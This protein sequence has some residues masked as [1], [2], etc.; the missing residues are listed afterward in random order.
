MLLGSTNNFSNVTNKILKRRTSKAAKSRHLPIIQNFID[1]VCIDLTPWKVW[2]FLSPIYS[3]WCQ[4][5]QHSKNPV[6]QN[7]GAI[8]GPVIAVRITNATLI[9]YSNVILMRLSTVEILPKA[10]VQT[11]EAAFL[12]NFVCQMLFHGNT[13]PLY[14]C[15]NNKTILISHHYVLS[16]TIYQ[17]EEWDFSVLVAHPSPGR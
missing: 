11:K 13:M 15:P 5:E 10:A 17:R 12:G 7:D 8:D 16:W 1:L 9:N 14:H 4:V 2:L 6:P 3:I